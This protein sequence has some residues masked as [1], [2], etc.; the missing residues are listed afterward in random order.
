[1]A[2]STSVVCQQDALNEDLA[3]NQ[4]ARCN[5]FNVQLNY[6]YN[7]ALDLELWDSNFHTVSLYGLIEYLASDVQNIKEFVECKDTF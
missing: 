1:M 3:L 7:Q 4:P 6:D 5:M 2:N